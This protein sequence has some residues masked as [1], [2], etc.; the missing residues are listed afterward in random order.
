MT[1]AAVDNAGANGPSSGPAPLLE[2]ARSLRMRHL[3]AALAICA[4]SR[5]P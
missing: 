1:V 3:G 4:L 5:R 2:A